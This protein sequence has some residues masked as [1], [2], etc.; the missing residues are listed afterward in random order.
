[1]QTSSIPDKK[2]KVLIAH[3]LA[4]IVSGAERSIA[5]FIQNADTE[6]EFCMLV[7][8]TGKLANYY[9]KRGISTW[10]RNVETPR[11][12]YPGL[13]QT[14]S[15]FFAKEVK[16]SDFDLVIGNTFA[17]ASRIRSVSKFA[18]LPR[19]NYIREYAN[20]N[21]VNARVINEIDHAFVI[22]KD[23]IKYLSS[24]AHPGQFHLT[25]NFIN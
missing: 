10:I 24:F 12:K 1:M 22:S 23:L 5:D 8:D 6:F 4:N 3:Y 9:K 20:N 16:Q 25:Y 18:G 7:P 21:K 14:Q 13:H 19:V 17:A 2:Y 15:Y 11:R